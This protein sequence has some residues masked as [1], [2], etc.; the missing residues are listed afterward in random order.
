LLFYKITNLLSR[1]ALQQF[2]IPRNLL[3][4]APVGF[5]QG[6]EG[7]DEA[8]R[9]DNR[10]EGHRA[11]EVDIAQQVGEGES[12]DEG[13]DLAER[14]RQPVCGTAHADRENLCRVDEGCDV[15]T[16]LGEEGNLSLLL[17][18]NSSK[19]CAQFWKL[20]LNHDDSVHNT[21]IWCT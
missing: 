1:F 11:G 9:G 21:P 6:E 17:I 16:E 3:Q 12:A 8:E 18:V 10:G 2:Q 13:P 5:G 19:K 7:E 20:C 15:G 4:R 14:G